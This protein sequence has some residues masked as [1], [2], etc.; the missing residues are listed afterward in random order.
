[1]RV[2]HLILWTVLDVEFMEQTIKTIISDNLYI[3]HS[4]HFWFTVLEKKQKKNIKY[5]YFNIKSFP[6]CF[7]LLLHT[8]GTFSEMDI[9]YKFSLSSIRAKITRTSFSFSRA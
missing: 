1:M 9:L 7:A 5:M 8:L 3:L 4:F 2:L 6:H